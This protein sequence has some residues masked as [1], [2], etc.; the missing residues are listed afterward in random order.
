MHSFPFVCVSIALIINKRVVVGVVHNPV[1]NETYTATRGGG[2]RLN[3][4]PISVSE[5]AGLGSAVF[6]TE[7]GTTRDA[8][9]V[10]AIFSRVRAL[11]AATRGVRCCGSCAVNL[12][13]VAM[14]RLDAF[15]EIGFG[16]C[17]DVAAGGLRG[18]V[19]GKLTPRIRHIMC[20][21][22]FEV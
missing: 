8:E 10:D 9:T 4:A 16:G 12:C 13:G 5:T 22:G 17:W 19:D 21:R 1:L 3:G 7:V 18:R 11:T 20:V 6:A 15:Y 14:G 2:A